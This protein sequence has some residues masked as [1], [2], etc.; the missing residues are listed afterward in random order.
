[1]KLPGSSE[2]SATLHNQSSVG[3]LGVTKIP[4]KVQKNDFTRLIA[5]KMLSASNGLQK[6]PKASMKQKVLWNDAINIFEQYFKLGLRN[7]YMLGVI[8]H[9]AK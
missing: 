5:P 8:N 9:F 2:K 1:M 7:G 4:I 3:R 6:K